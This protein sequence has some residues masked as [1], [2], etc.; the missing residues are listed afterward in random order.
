MWFRLAACCT[1]LWIN[2][3]VFA[4]DAFVE[5]Q[6]IT[7]ENSLGVNYS[8]AD[9]F[10]GKV[11]FS[12][13]PVM[14]SQGNVAPSIVTFEAG[15]YS[16][17]HSHPNGQYLIVVE[18]EGRTQEW[19]GEVQTIRKGD[20]IWC[21]PGVKH[22]HG[23]SEHSAMSHLAISPVPREGESVIWMEKVKLPEHHAVRI[24]KQAVPANSV[25]S[26]RQQKIIPVAAFTATGDIAKLKPA[27]HTALDAG[28]SIN[29]IKEVMIHLYAYA[30]FPRSLNGINTLIETLEQRKAQGI[31]DLPGKEASEL[32]ENY[33]ANAYGNRVRNEITGRDLTHN[34]SG[35]AQFAPVID[36]FLKEHLFGD[37]F[38]R[39]VLSYQDRQLTTI[40]VLAALEGTEAQLNAHL[41]V[42]LNVGLTI[43]QLSAFVDVL[44][45]EV[46]A[47]AAQKTQRLL[48]QLQ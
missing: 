11:S 36:V 14:P 34:P 6:V 48:G 28:V 46:S 37:I 15:D 47:D 4:G 10:T 16:N 44:H 27:L 35:Y 25:L 13:Y 21:P 1:I 8:S 2:T 30:G 38:V 43:Q 40:S 32:P 18:G 17:W 29:E 19:G 33:N 3:L 42:S 5:S 31:K 23:A 41:R 9:K 26:V 24:D 12:R 45:S 7:R 20:V 39:D 22:W